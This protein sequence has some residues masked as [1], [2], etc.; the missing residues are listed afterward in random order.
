MI[1]KIL[2]QHNKMSKDG[3]VKNIYALFKTIEDVYFVYINDEMLFNSLDKEEA[4]EFYEICVKGYKF[5]TSF[6]KEDLDN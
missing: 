4:E 3:I 2:S 6:R 1:K 5:F